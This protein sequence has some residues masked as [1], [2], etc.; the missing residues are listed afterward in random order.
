MNNSL[1][2]AVIPIPVLVMGCN[3]LKVGSATKQA[4]Q[5]NRRSK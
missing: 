1:A 5:T 2:R 3:E 4:G